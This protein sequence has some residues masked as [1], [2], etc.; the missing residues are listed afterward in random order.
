MANK[1]IIKGQEQLISES[2]FKSENTSGLVLEKIFILDPVSRGGLD[3]KI[4]QDLK[5]S[6]VLEFVFDDDTV[7]VTDRETLHDLFPENDGLRSAEEGFEIPVSIT[8]AY[9][10]RGWLKNIGLK[11]IRLFKKKETVADIKT[12]V[13]QLATRLEVQQLEARSGLYRIDEIFNLEDTPL[14]NDALNTSEPFLLFI[15]GTAS[16]TRG[17]YGHITGTELWT[18]ITDSYRDRIFAFEHESLTKSPLQNA[19]DLADKLPV[20]ANLHVIS[21]SR[22]GLVGDIL[23]RFS[24]DNTGT[25]GFSPAEVDY[26]RK[27]GRD[28]DADCIEALTSLFLKKNIA[29]EK[30]V[31]ISC[32]GRGTHLA[33]GRLDH[34]LNMILNFVGYATGLAPNP[35][36]M[37]L[38]DLI[39]AVIDCKNDLEVLPGIEAMSPGSDFIKVLNNPETFID[40]RL[41]VIAGNSKAELSLKGIAVIASKLFFLEKNDLIVHTAS[42]SQGTRRTSDI[43]YFLDEGTDVDHFHYISNKRTNDAIRNALNNQFGANTGFN[44]IRQEATDKLDRN[45]LLALEYGDVFYDKVTG[46]RPIVVILPGIMGSSLRRRDK[47]IWI[48][49]FKFLSGNLTSLDIESAGITADALIKTSYSKLCKFLEPNYDVVTF[50]FDWRLSMEVNAA[51]FNDK[52]TQLLSYKQP[53]KIIGHSMGGVLVRDFIINHPATWSTLNQ[54]AGF[55]IIFLGAPLAGSFRILYVL[56]GRDSLIKTLSTVDIVHTRKE[57][58]EVFSRFPGLLSLLPTDSEDFGNLSLWDK[59]MK[60]DREEEW[61]LPF[62]DDL[63]TFDDYRQKILL[64]SSGIDYSNIVYIAGKD[65]ATVSGYKIENTSESNPDG[66]LQFYFTAEGDQSVTWESGIPKKL[67]EQNSVYYVNVTHGALANE[68]LMFGGLS[69]LLSSGNTVQFSKVRPVVRSD[70]RYFRM[71]ELFTFDGSQ[72]QFENNILGLPPAEMMQASDA[73]LKVIIS[74]GDLKYSSYPILAGH[75]LNDGILY[76]E[77][78]IDNNLNG[79]LSERHSLGLYPGEIGTSEIVINNNSE[80]FKGA[81]IVGLDYPERLTPFQLSLTIEKAVIRYLLDLQ[82]RNHSG[83]MDPMDS[84]VGITSLIIGCGYG[85][86][87][88]ESSIKA[89]IQGIDGANKKIKAITES[90]PVLIEYIE[91]IEQYKD[92]C[93]SAFDSLKRLEGDVN[94]PYNVSL[95]SNKIKSKLGKKVRLPLEAQNEWWNRITVRLQDDSESSRDIRRLVFNTSTGAAREEQ[96]VIASNYKVLEDLLFDISTNNQWSPELARVIFELLIPNDFKDQLKKQNNINWILDKSTAAFPWELLQDS[97]NNADPLSVNAGM[98]RQLTTQDYRLKVSPATKNTALVVGDPDLKGYINQLPGALAESKLVSEILS[99]HN[100]ETETCLRSEAR[101]IIISLLK[102]EYQIIHLAGHG[103]Y[104]EQLS[105]SG[106]VIG[107]KTFLTTSDIAQMSTVPELVFVNCC[108]LGNVNAE[109]ERYYRNRYKLAASIG[110]QLIENGVRAVVAAGWAVDDDAASLFAEVFYKSMFSGYTF[111]EAVHQARKTVYQKYRYNNNTWGAYQCYGDPFY[112]LNNIQKSAPSK[113]EKFVISEQAEIKLTNL[114][115][116]LDT[117]NISDDDYVEKLDNI[118]SAVDKAGIRNARITESEAIIYTNLGMYD[119]ALEKY[120]QLFR[121]EEASFTFSALEKY[122]NVLAKSN[123][124]HAGDA[125]I[126]VGIDRALTLLGYLV[127]LFPTAERINLLASTYKRKAML[128]DKEEDKLN[129]LSKAAFNYHNAWGCR[130]N[131]NK[132]YTL[133]NW[134][135]SEFILSKYGVHK[136]NTYTKEHGTNNYK[137]PSTVQAKDMLTQLS[138]QLNIEF[139]DMAYWDMISSANIRLCQWIL[140]GS[141]PGNIE[142]VIGVY[143]PTWGIAGS[144]AKKIGEMEHLDFLLHMFKIKEQ[145]NKTLIRGIEKVKETLLLWMD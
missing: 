4:E 10:P 140:S 27:T 92:R 76:A 55:R 121:F 134:L 115:Y 96:R 74:N 127:E 124:V 54:S 13:R 16:S 7:W 97:A 104:D 101:N 77:Q 113:E 120:D 40:N 5:D 38:K 86:Q 118:G 46:E 78:A 12:L 11:L 91:F 58:L 122:C 81:I 69:E 137:I 8:N 98:I 117:G 102:R 80:G 29:V 85:G 84:S 142:E 109:N 139:R 42:M 106:M 111:G 34:L 68:P 125:I 70:M 25:K 107:E 1:I 2:T 95:V 135:E 26:L 71:P 39:S 88:I 108:Y 94:Q 21:S 63:K 49:Y 57:L 62:H 100:F 47:K 114:I 6:H 30:F 50:P 130:D 79:S 67:I 17:S 66:D 3:S 116:Q 59:I 133:I 72:T 64:K 45:A 138:A 18:Y 103:V 52:I 87:S 9:S 73:P 129:F 128:A 83:A 28:K 22:G 60:A 90:N 132:A 37:L 24:N 136:W 48:N 119:K 53:I 145:E 35:V 82:N 93:L 20:N 19:L 65:K 51:R 99:T 33:S 44:I 141:N 131:N 23:A 36:Y 15:H 110:T 14:K 61:P 43:Y 144:K 31:R 32:P 75:F 143:K 89:I 126:S 105:E 56:T 41:I 123:I 112:R